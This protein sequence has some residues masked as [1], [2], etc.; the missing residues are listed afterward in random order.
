MAQALIALDEGAKVVAHVADGTSSR[1][2]LVSIAALELNVGGDEG[3]IP[4][5]D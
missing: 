4:G 3:D 2:L 5:A 1:P